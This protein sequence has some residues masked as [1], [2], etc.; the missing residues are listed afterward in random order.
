MFIMFDHATVSMS[1]SPTPLKM[2]YSFGE[3][4]FFPLHHLPLSQH[5]MTDYI[6]KLSQCIGFQIKIIPMSVNY[7]KTI[8]I[9]IVGVPTIP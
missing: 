2:V 9:K 1:L 7:N 8:K 5:N 4:D 6:L 3:F